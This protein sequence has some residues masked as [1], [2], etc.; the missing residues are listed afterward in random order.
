[1]LNHVY[2]NMIDGMPAPYV[3]G[4]ATELWWTDR[5]GCTVTSVTFAKSGKRKGQITQFTMTH[6]RVVWDMSGGEGSEKVKSYETV[7]GAGEIVVK[8]RSN[9]RWKTTGGQYVSVGFRDTYRD[10]HF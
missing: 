2:A 3:G 4:P 10:P 5:Y 1:M 9:G 6:D 7:E 8:L